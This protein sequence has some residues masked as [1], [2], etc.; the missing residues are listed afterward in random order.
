MKDRERALRHKLGV[1]DA[2]A[3]ILIFEQSAHCD[4]DWACIHPAYYDNA[5]GT[6]G[7]DQVIKILSDAFIAIAASPQAP[8]KPAPSEAVEPF[9]YA[10]CEV[11]YLRDFH[12]SI[13]RQPAGAPPL[14]TLARWQSDI[15][16]NRFHFSS[17]GIT[18]AENLI[19]HTEAFIRNYLL[20][21]QW[22]SDTFGVQ[23]SLQMWVP[24][25]FG[26]DAQLPVLL[27]AMGFTG[28]GF[29]RIPAQY[30]GPSGIGYSVTAGQSTYTATASPD[31]P[32]SFLTGVDYVWSARDGSQIQAHWLS[33]CYNQ[34]NI[35]VTTNGTPPPPPPT[36]G[37]LV[38]TSLSNGTIQNLIASYT[39]APPPRY[40]FV[41]IDNDFC[42]PY[43]NFP[44]VV[45][46]W[47][48]TQAKTTNV[49]VVM[50]T[51]DD[52]MKLVAAA[53][54]ETQSLPR[55]QSNPSSGNAY[56]PHPYWSGCYASFP[57]IKR[58]HYHATR[59]LLAA[60]AHQLALQYLA[61]LG[62]DGQTVAQQSLDLIDAGWTLLAPSTHHDYITGTS[63]NNVI[64]QEQL[65]LLDRADVAAVTARDHVHAALARA[66]KPL[67]G[68]SG[69]P[70]VVFNPIAL[71]RGDVIEI[72]VPGA[73]SYSSFT[74]DG[75]TYRPVQAVASD[76]LLTYGPMPAL[77]YAAGV[78]NTTNPNT[79][80]RVAV[81]SDNDVFELVNDYLRATITTKGIAALYEFGKDGRGS[82]LFGNPTANDE[83]GNALIHFLDSGTIY[84]FGSEQVAEQYL[85]Y[86][87]TPGQESNGMAF[88]P[89]ATTL[90]NLTITAG[91]TGPTPI[92][93]S[94]IV[95]GTVTFPGNSTADFTTVYQLNAFDKFVRVETTSHVPAAVAPGC[96]AMV[97][98]PFG[99]M[100][101]IAELA[102]GTTAHWDSRAPRQNFIAWTDTGG[103][104]SPPP[105]VNEITFEPTHEYVVPLDSSGA[106]LGAIYH[107]SAP[108][109]AISLDGTALLGCVLRN[110]PSGGQGAK[111]SDT[112][113]H[114]QAYAV[115]IPSGL[116]MPGT[117]CGAGTPL[118]EALMYNNPLTGFPISSATT[119]QL[120]T[121]M[122]IAATTDPSALVTVAKAGTVD[123]TQMIVR[124]Y[125]PTD[126]SLGVEVTVAPQIAGLF[127]KAGVL[128]TQAVTALEQPI[129]NGGPIAVSANS[130]SLTMP[131]AMA[132]VALDAGR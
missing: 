68:V 13:V 103:G 12:A 62:G 113:T 32:S 35:F 5:N 45:A 14:P 126:A 71:A 84:R 54:E 94:V 85:P 117:G 122:S 67:A 39:G 43:M 105:G 100:Q 57:E 37:T 7:G 81:S 95:R 1:S 51:F 90:S 119:G 61:T 59:T 78:L 27:Q 48:A 111:A 30:G 65:P 26:H 16:A 128:Q 50:A 40:M 106:I 96:S 79:G 25:D 69:T 24:D 123:N 132:T 130:L 86:P 97:S 77:G 22:V 58:L 28:A 38:D 11:G 20:G 91:E 129:T 15:D 75:V 98:F 9:T 89:M 36:D 52:F 23:P 53:D 104:T 29:W 4:W 110:A 17:G 66:V 121:S 63:P 124:L 70:V 115:R 31:A 76:R 3:Q 56:L 21:R 33:G 42:L 107:R 92:R 118:G 83:F 64:A 131:Y 60:E 101:P 125:Q 44:E 112:A 10:F 2:T 46:N 116:A 6:N 99:A 47:N 73:A 109:W 93:A 19:V 72:T 8:S 80:V 88:A 114:T 108:A 55:L 74:T 41:P 102:Y 127:Q 87:T 120:P 82:N 18:S 49:A 34:G